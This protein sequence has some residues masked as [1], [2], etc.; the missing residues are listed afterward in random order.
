MAFKIIKTE[1]TNFS[2]PQEMFQDNKMK[3]IIGL[4]DYQSKMI[5]N[6][7]STIQ[8]NGRIKDKHVA[9]ELP[10]GSGKT[11]I[12]LLICEFHRR[13]YHHKAL[14]LCP[15]NQLVAQVC[16][17]AKEQYGI[18]AIAFIGKQ[19]EYSPS[20]RSSYSLGKKIGVTTYSSFFATSEYFD[21]TDILIFD[22][23]HSSEQY[24]ADNWSVNIQK[25]DYPVLYQELA[26]VIK[27]TKI[28]ESF[29]HRMSASPTYEGD[30]MDWCNLVP[31]PMI[32]SKLA[33]IFSIINSYADGSNLS[34]SWSRICDHLRECNIFVSWASILIRPFI[35]P[36]L[37]FSPFRNAKQCIYMSATLGKSGELERITG[38]EK[39][40]R[41]P[42]V[43]EWDKKAIGR[44]LFIFPDLSFEAKK[45]T[46]IIIELHQLCKKSVVIVPNSREQKELTNIVKSL[47]PETKVYDTQDLIKSKEEFK[48]QKDAMVI[49]SNRFDGIDFPDDDCRMLI[50]QNLPKVTHLQEKFFYSKMAASILYSERIKTKIVQA[51]GRC[52]RNAKDYAAVC[53][54]GNSVLSDFIT[55]SNLKDYKPELRAEIKLGIENSIELPD[56]SE[57][58]ENVKLF[59]SRDSSW[60]E[61]EEQIVNLRDSYIQQDAECQDNSLFDKLKESSIKEVKLQYVLWKKD[62][63]QAFSIISEIID[64]LNA[65][66][67]KGYRAFWRYYA[68]HIAL[69]LGGD[70]LKKSHELF[71]CASYDVLSISWLAKLA[72]IGQEIHVDT[73]TDTGINSTIERI[74]KQ[75]TM[76]ST[77]SKLE[78]KIKEIL[79]GL[80]GSSGEDFEKHH[81]KLGE[82][83]GYNASNP[84]EKGAPDPYW[85]INDDICIVSEDKIY[86]KNTQKIPLAHISQAKRHEKWIRENIMTLHHSA[87]IYTVFIS[88]ASAIEEECRIHADNIYYCN[89]ND[90][91]A[92]AHKALKVLRQC[93]NT[94]TEEGD[95]EWREFAI[96]EFTKNAVT[97]KDFIDL[98]TK[99]KLNEL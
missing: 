46:D 44:K 64:V 61:V 15:T 17:Q 49:I 35:A 19:S 74:E 50:I 48:H 82:L 91:I 94:F 71:K 60:E 10:T 28:G 52:T 32:E 18:E 31:I 47:L 97:P 33:D 13:K 1:G 90:L 62:Y 92:W 29:Y 30:I 21:G 5:D 65:P 73:K 7:M 72:E 51:V 24:I 26:E 4:I 41:L 45:H 12:G 76:C 56:I 78:K 83:L 87:K 58:I 98:I 20:D 3:N 88:N 53:V 89:Q 99:T 9:F 23:V 16:R 36:T 8:E 25:E 68:G 80:T 81:E 22:D 95:A 57:I 69:N 38:V 27:D 14:F 43:N 6:Y 96:T 85:I 84:K 63:S 39:I 55:D 11:L 77:S 37:S 34:Y 79:T 93:Y 42:I 40:K 54:L 2:T 66:K 70:Y 86:N 59:L 67:L 75:L